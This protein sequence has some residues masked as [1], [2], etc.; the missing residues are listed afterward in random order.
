MLMLN[1]TEVRKE[2]SSVVD[3]V[4]REKPQFIKR[5]RDYMFLSDI[6]TMDFLLSAYAFTA[7][8]FV[9]EDGSITLALNE[10]DL[11]ENGGNEKDARLKLAK[12]I[13]EYAEDFYQE[14]ALWSAAPNRKNHLPYVL[15]ALIIDNADKIGDLI[16]CQAG[17]N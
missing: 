5:T 9:E 8:K 14:F 17:G 7:Q 16:Q 3:A 13:M 4:I 11:A 6:K 10:I 2:W 12:A 1:A 15:K